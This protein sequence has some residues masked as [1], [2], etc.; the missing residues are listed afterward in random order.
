MKHVTHA[1]FVLDEPKLEVHDMEFKKIMLLTGQN[2]TGK[3]LVMK[4]IWAMSTLGFMYLKSGGN[5]R[6]LATFIINNT[7]DSQNFTGTVETTHLNGR[8][9]VTLESGVVTSAFCDA[10]DDETLSTPIFMSTTLRLFSAVKAAYAMLDALGPEK[11]LQHYRL[12]DLITLEI[13]KARFAAKTEPPALE[14]VNKIFIDEGQEP[15]FD[16]F[17]Y[18]GG[19]IWGYKESSRRDLAT[20]SNGEQAWINMALLT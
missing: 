18:D 8:I 10:V 3:S 6:E 11:F 19:T 2:G 7:F 14:M 17:Q 1:T 5:L 16:S 4:F 9:G 15:K 13:Y 12:Y 20:L